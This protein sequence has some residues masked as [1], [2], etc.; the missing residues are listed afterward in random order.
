MECAL[1]I[2]ATPIG[3]LQDITLRA[4]STLGEVDLIA[5]ED[6]RRTGQLLQ[7]FSIETPLT[8]YHEHSDAGVTQ[9]LCERLRA[10]SSIA[11]VSDAGTPMIS[12]PG[13]RLVRAAQ[14]AGI[15]VVPVPG[16]CAAVA[17]LS[18]AGLPSDRFL[19]SGFLPARSAARRSALE[20]LA[21]ESA[22]LIF[23]EAP[24]RLR[25]SLADL[26]AVFGPEREAVLAREIS[27][28]FE[29]IRRA[30]LVE[31]EA[32]VAGDSDQCRGEIVLLVSGAPSRDAEV[33]PALDALMHSLC[34][35]LPPREVASLLAEY[36]G[37]RKNRL[38]AHWLASQQAPETD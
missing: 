6:T 2:V 5:A 27:K 28:T 31:L 32:F 29:T 23:Y 10:G 17:A 7:H 37:V 12:D 38:Y 4:L 13:Y 18:A 9:R 22:T 30:P 1:Y 19:F 20:A 16:A 14:E 34:A 8:A 24:H 11:L 25:D 36:S 3:N 35:R 15:P 26:V 33:D 21:G